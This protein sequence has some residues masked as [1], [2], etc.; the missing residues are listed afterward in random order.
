[1]VSQAK[2]DLAGNAHIDAAWL[3]PRT[4]TVDV[5][6]RTFTT[7]LQLMNEYPDYTFSQSAAQ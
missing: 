3:W 1:M 4:E 6:R 2:V 7:A 5:V